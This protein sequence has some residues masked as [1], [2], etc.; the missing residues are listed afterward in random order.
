MILRSRTSC[1]S[2]YAHLEHPTR[3]GG[4]A[5]DDS[6]S[7]T[8]LRPVNRTA[9]MNPELAYVGVVYQVAAEAIVPLSSQGGRGVGVTAGLEL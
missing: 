7:L 2:L 6:V 1:S 3:E 9:R 8:L 5:T 4:D